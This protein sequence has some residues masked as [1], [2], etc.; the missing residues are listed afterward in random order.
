MEI[1]GLKLNRLAKETDGTK[2]LDGLYQS[3]W[4]GSWRMYIIQKKR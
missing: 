1:M 2:R 4:F 3:I